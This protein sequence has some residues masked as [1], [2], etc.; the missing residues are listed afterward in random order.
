MA[1]GDFLVVKNPTAL[2][3]PILAASVWFQP[4]KG[5]RIALGG[6]NRTKIP[7]P[8]VE[9]PQAPKEGRKRILAKCWR[10]G[11][12]LSRARIYS[13]ANGGFYYFGGW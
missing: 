6:K 1:L 3:G 8:P 12:P 10:F 2:V 7:A 4:A 13:A 5:V 11:F 9:I